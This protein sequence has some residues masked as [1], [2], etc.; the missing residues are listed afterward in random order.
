MKHMRLIKSLLVLLLIAVGVN[1]ASA[2]SVK[3]SI[4]K[5]FLTPGERA[6]ITVNMT[7]DIDLTAFSGMVEL[8]DGQ[9]RMGQSI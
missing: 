9:T 2:Q 4:D 6:S 5:T 7:S 3:F 1:M 8:P